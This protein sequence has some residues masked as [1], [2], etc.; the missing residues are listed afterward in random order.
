M[1]APLPDNETARIGQL[2]EAEIL[3][4]PPEPAYDA[5]VKLAAQMCETPMA[6]VSLIDGERQWFK[7]AVGLEGQETARDYAFCAHAIREPQTMLI[8][9]DAT[10]D[11]RFA[12]NPLVTGPPDIRFYAGFP[13]QSSDGHALG[14]L[15]VIDRKVRTLSD[16]QRLLLESLAKHTAA[17]I[18][19]RITLTRLRRSENARHET[20]RRFESLAKHSPNLIWMLDA[21]GHVEYANPTTIAVCGRTLEEMQGAGWI[22]LVHADDRQRVAEVFERGLCEAKPIEVEFRILSADGDYRW[23]L[24]AGRPRWED[25]GAFAGYIGTSTDITERK[26]AKE[27]LLRSGRNA[28]LVIESVPNGIL[29]VNRAG[30]I[31]LANS[32]AEKLYGY[33]QGELVGQPVEILIAAPFRET[34]GEKHAEY[35]SHPQRQTL[36]LTTD[37][38]GVRKDGSEFPVEV[39]LSPIEVDGDA[40]VLCSVIDLTEGKRAKAQLREYAERLTLATRAGGVGIWE[41]N[42]T[43]NVLIWDEQMFR[44]YGIAPDL[45][46]GAFDAWR[47]G[48]HPD[49][50]QRT[51]DE[52]QHAL[53]GEG[54]FDTEFRVVWSDGT[55]H[56]IRALAVVERDDGGRPTRMVGTNWDI[57]E[58]KRGEE[59]LKQVAQMKSEFLANMSHEIRT[60]MNV[61]IGMS[62]LLADTE[63]SGDQADYTQTIRRGAESLL[64]VI[65]GVLDFSKL[66][67]GRL[68][69]DPEDFSIDSVAEDTV[70]FFAQLARQKGLDLTC[71][72]AANVPAWA[73]G[74]RSRLRQILTNLIGNALKFTEQGGVSL[75]VDWAGR[76][77]DKS[78]IR[79]AV[80][81]T[82]IG[83]SQ[84]VQAQLFQAFTQADG[85]TTRKY[86]GSGLGLAISKR[87]AEMMGGGISIE[88]AP[89]KGSTFLLQ[90]PFGEPLESKPPEPDSLPDLAGARVLVV[91]DLESNRN[92]VG[93]YLASWQMKVDAAEN[94]LQAMTKVREAVA[95]GQPYG[96]VLLDCG[97]PGMSGIDVARLIAFDP[98]IKATPLIMLT[99]YDDRNELKGAKEVGMAA[100]LTKPVRKQMLRRAIAR[101]LTPQAVMPLAVK[102]A[103]QPRAGTRL[104]L[105]EDNAD[106]QK[107]A[108]RLLGK[109]GYACDIA[110]NGSEAL[111]KL[112]K[113]SY[114]VVL[115]D[116]QMPQMDGF[117]AT[118]A[119]REREV[120]SARRT[121][122]IAMTAHALAEDRERCL[123]AGMDDYIS[124]PINERHLVAAIQ[125]WLPPLPMAKIPAALEALVPQYL[126]NRRQDLVALAEAVRRGDLAAAGMIGHSMKGSGAGY[127]FPAISDMGGCIE[128][129]AVAKDAD[130]VLRHTAMLGD[131]LGRVG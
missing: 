98:R 83:I 86:G 71:F 40:S 68:E 14:T 69:L 121:P 109:H 102:A 60:P 51:D 49:D 95:A 25:S 39:T 41:F 81:D 91:D 100:F 34:T 70:E 97:M 85:S 47:A 29:I 116:C 36:G 106:N 131:Y 78:V 27:I 44:L 117:E 110:A 56:Y 84:E 80:Q 104:L 17:L 94:G 64:G 111:A 10:A 23:L 50:Q 73:R 128:N 90:L 3:D 9:P 59:K 75:R 26:R 4:T 112:E 88:S 96:L 92:I 11:E 22:D 119:I 74:D 48:V 57:T 2:K 66:E 62:G 113:Q 35:L 99:S 101:A 24:A 38:F 5:I 82:G 37:H 16:E 103:P 12:D 31:T 8:V 79:F 125:R 52:I 107:L 65:N 58:R 21:Q 43:E 1:R 77:G 6:A 32:A 13:L 19:T 33:E 55:I 63:L 20:D 61:I 126:A 118:K 105:V 15:C 129:C 124:K 89:G 54:D 53:R 120:N 18:E 123:A 108:T 30:A 87:L 42:V 127:G 67:A 7:A 45:S 72:V 76:S 130:G 115:M 46:S 122:I 28:Q 93:Q 114:P